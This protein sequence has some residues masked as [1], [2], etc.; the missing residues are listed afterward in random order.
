M[1]TT[2][3]PDLTAL[4]ELVRT[5]FMP[6]VFTCGCNGS[7]ADCADILSHSDVWT[8]RDTVERIAKLIEN[9]K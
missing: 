8:Q 7:H 5:K 4:A 2:T 6:L 3:A 1:T 9:Y